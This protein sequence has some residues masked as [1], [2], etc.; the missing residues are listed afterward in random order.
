MTKTQFFYA[1]RQRLDGLPQEEAVKALEYCGEMIDDRIEDGLGEEEA[2][3]ALG[4]MD[5]IIMQI[6][7]DIPLTKLVGEK[8]KPRSIGT[9]SLVLI[10]LGSPI[11]LSLLVAAV[12]VALSVYAVI[13]SVVLVLYAV[14]FSLAACGVGGV[15]AAIILLFTGNFTQAAFLFG[16]GIFSAGLA[17]LFFFVCNFVAKGMLWLSKKIL[18]AVKRC[19]IKKEAKA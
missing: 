13:W 14:D 19:F 10:I 8:L 9:W 5:E 3:A 12:A 15:V 18:L 1:L 4:S 11:W 7:T 2:V 6:L 16:C 17:I